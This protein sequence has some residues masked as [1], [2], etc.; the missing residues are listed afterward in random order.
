MIPRAPI[1]CG[2]LLLVSAAGLFAATSESRHLAYIAEATLGAPLPR[3]GGCEP[4]PKR[5]PRTQVVEWQGAAGRWVAEQRDLQADY[6][7]VFGGTPESVTAIGF[8]IDT[9]QT[10]VAAGAH[11]GSVRWI[12][13]P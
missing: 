10:G 1:L 13:A 5:A 8:M 11:L 4:F 2:V 6:R 7:T 3:N 9:E 12:S